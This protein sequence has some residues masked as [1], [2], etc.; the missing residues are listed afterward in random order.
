MLWHE[1]LGAIG[2]GAG[3]DPVEEHTVGQEA[4]LVLFQVGYRIG[5]V[6]GAGGSLRH[7]GVRDGA[8]GVPHLALTDSPSVMTR[9]LLALDHAQ[10]LRIDKDPQGAADMATDVWNELP[11][12]FRTGLVQ[13]R[14]EALRNA[15]T[16]RPRAQLTEVLSF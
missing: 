12:G 6:E 16:G 3:G 8:L 5:E 15:L 1:R 10:C 7:G 13:T 14:A 9:A 4:F 11:T 2:H